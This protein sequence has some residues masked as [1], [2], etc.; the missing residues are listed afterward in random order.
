MNLHG[1][2]AS[3][4]HRLDATTK[5]LIVCNV[6]SAWFLSTPVSALGSGLLLTLVLIFRGFCSFRLV[7]I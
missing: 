1:P 6:C 7:F 3:Q 5:L 4:G 2:S